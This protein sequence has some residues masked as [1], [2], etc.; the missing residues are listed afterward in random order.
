MKK[1]REYVLAKNMA[2][3]VEDNTLT[4]TWKTKM[5]VTDSIEERGCRV[6]LKLNY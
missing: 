5:L 2:S 6:I 1:T 3:S 4:E